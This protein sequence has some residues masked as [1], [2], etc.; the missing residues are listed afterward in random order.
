MG[1]PLT[2]FLTWLW[3]SW[4][5]SLSAAVITTFIGIAG[6]VRLQPAPVPRPPSGSDGAPARSKCSLSS[7]PS[8]PCSCCCSRSASSGRL[9][10]LNTHIG[11]ILVYLGG[12]IGFNT[13]LLKGFMDSIP[14]SLDE[15]A[16]VDGATP[17][18]L[19]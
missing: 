1:D 19:F 18:Q 7:S 14:N 4:K 5:V 16:E 11:L 17:W 15:S 2:P 12:A 6:R 9:L 8:S 10:G 13:F 3:N